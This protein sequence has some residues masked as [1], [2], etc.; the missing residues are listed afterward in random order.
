M[1]ISIQEILDELQNPQRNVSTFLKAQA[2]W[3]VKNILL[4]SLPLIII[5]I[6]VII[7]VIIIIIIIIMPMI[8]MTTMMMM[9][10]LRSFDTSATV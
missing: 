9:M 2:C 7:V 3:D 4:G 8:I 6:I 5:T 10:A 1:C